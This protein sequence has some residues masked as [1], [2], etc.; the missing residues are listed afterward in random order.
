MSTINKN[1]ISRT[2]GDS[3]DVSQT[4]I[5]NHIVE[6]EEEHTDPLIFPVPRFRLNGATFNYYEQSIDGISVNLNNQ[7]TLTYNYTANTDSFSAI[8]KVLYDV[9]RINFD[10]YEQVLNNLDEEGDEIASVTSSTPSI[11]TISNLLSEPLVQ[12]VESGNSITYPQNIYEFPEL[13]KPVGQFAEQLLNDKAQYFVDTRFQFIQERDR[14]LG[15]FQIL[16]GGTAIDYT[17]TG[18]SDSG[19]FLLE[20]E[21]DSEIITGGTFS[22]LS[23]NGAFFTYFVAPQKPNIDVVNDEPTVKGSLPTFSPIWSFNNVDDGDYYKLQVTYDITNFSF[24][25]A[26]TFNIPRQEG[27]PDFIRTFSTPLTPQTTF[28]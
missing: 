20:T 13:V 22:G 14:S 7:K 11:S 28:I 2:V 15:G 6:A 4:F 27:I 23:V 24:L 1:I 12:L 26:T 9:Y 19:D 17:L 3:N 18:L 5:Q 8:T 21:G 10:T 16:S 25:S